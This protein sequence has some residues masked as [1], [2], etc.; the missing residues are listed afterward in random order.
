M[1]GPRDGGVCFRTVIGER[2]ERDAFLRTG[3]SGGDLGLRRIFCGSYATRLIPRAE[4]PKTAS[5]AARFR[6]GV[7]RP[8]CNGDGGGDRLRESGDDARL[9]IGDNCVGDLRL[10]DRLRLFRLRLYRNVSRSL[11]ELLSPSMYIFL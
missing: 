4:G 9:R 11:S 2:G 7:R 1:G 5:G 3:G 8:R 6:S 10:R